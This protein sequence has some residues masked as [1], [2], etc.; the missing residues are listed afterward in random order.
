MNRKQRRAKIKRGKPTKR[1]QRLYDAA[2]ELF[3]AS[4]CLRCGAQDESKGA[5]MLAGTF[6]IVCNDC[7]KDADS[8]IAT[9]TPVIE[10]PYPPQIEGLTAYEVTGKPKRAEF[11]KVSDQ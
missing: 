6:Q 5:A 4:G 9:I 10:S 7:V 2:M 3:R 11:V 8:I 1:Q